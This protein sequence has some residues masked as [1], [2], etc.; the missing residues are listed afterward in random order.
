MC[1]ID[2]VVGSRYGGRPTLTSEVLE[3]CGLC[4]IVTCRRNEYLIPFISLDFACYGKA[5]DFALCLPGPGEVIFIPESGPF[6]LCRGTPGSTPI[7][8]CRIILGFKDSLAVC[9]VVLLGLIFAVNLLEILIGQ[10]RIAFLSS[11]VL[12]SQRIE[13]AIVCL[14][15]SPGKEIAKVFRLVGAHIASSPFQ[16]ITHLH[17]CAVNDLRLS[18]T[19]SVKFFLDLFKEPDSGRE[20]NLTVFQCRECCRIKLKGFN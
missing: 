19:R 6:F 10:E 2:A 12:P 3:D 7:G 5:F 18:L 20:R 14:R 17:I 8:C 1:M 15:H 9:S 11:P 4:Y 13:T 16:A